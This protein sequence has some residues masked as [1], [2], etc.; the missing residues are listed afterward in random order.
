MNANSV[1]PFNVA[2]QMLDAFITATQTRLKLDDTKPTTLRYATK[3]N[4]VDR[5]HHYVVSFAS[6]NSA[7]RLHSLHSPRIS[8]EP[9]SLSICS[10]GVKRS[11]PRPRFCN[12]PGI[13]KCSNPLDAS[14]PPVRLWDHMDLRLQSLQ[15]QYPDLK[16]EVALVSSQRL[17]STS[18]AM[19][20]TFYNYEALE[21]VVLTRGRRCTGSSCTTVF[22]DDY[23]Y[24]RDI[25]QTN[26]VDWYGI[27][28]TLRGA[29]QAYVWIR[30]IFLTYGAYTAVEQRDGQELGWSSRLLAT[31]TLVLKIPFQVIVYSGL[32]PVS[33]YVGALVLDSSFTDVFLDSYWASVGGSVNFQLV[34]FLET[35]VVQMRNSRSLARRSGPYKMATL[36]DT[37]ISSVFRIADEGPT[38]DNIHCNPSGYMNAS[39]YIF[40]DSATMLLFCIG[41]VTALAIGVKAF[42]SFT[43]RSSWIHRESEGVV[44]S[45]TPIVPRGTRRLWPTSI[46]NIRFHAATR[47]SDV[48]GPRS[49]NLTPLLGLTVPSKPQVASAPTIDLIPTRHGPSRLVRPFSLVNATGSTL[50]RS[51]LRGVHWRSTEFRSIAQLMNV[52]MMTDLWNLLWLRVLGIQVYL[53]QIHRSQSLSN[54]RPSSFAVLLP[55]H[56]DEVEEYTG[57]SAGEYELLDSANSKDIPMPVL[58]QCG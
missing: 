46:L 21:I 16:L 36:R 48:R 51:P 8:L 26:L 5:L 37:N 12:H 38:M 10:N 42:G 28:S 19:R 35:T 39:S 31:A 52:A 56:E 22:V 17:S 25:V 30:L 40:D 57:L 20:S 18:G 11:P 55:F 4:W 14:L 2:F 13:W 7:W 45:S 44:L 33:F 34:P 23:R 43:P 58:L 9:L 24:E 1:I 49:S 41:A 3:H 27:I 50:R 32:L 15:R 54:R 29:A 53:Y 47:P 6:K